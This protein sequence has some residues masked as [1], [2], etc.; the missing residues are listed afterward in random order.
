MSLGPIG[1]EDVLK[2]IDKTKTPREIGRE[3][4]V[5]YI[6]EGSVRKL[7][8]KVRLGAKLISADRENTIWSHNF[9]F[10]IDEIFDIEIFF[11]KNEYFNNRWMW[12]HWSSFC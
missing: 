12:V 5:R 1:G 2:K 6:L 10:N 11:N 7:G 3:L 4:G 8:Q 9:D